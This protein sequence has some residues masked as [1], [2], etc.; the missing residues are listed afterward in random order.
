MVESASLVKLIPT[1]RLGNVYSSSAA[2][3]LSLLGL[4]SALHLLSSELVLAT[5]DFLVCYGVLELE[6]GVG[7]LLVVLVVEA[8]VCNAGLEG[9]VAACVSAVGPSLAV[10]PVA[11]GVRL[12]GGSS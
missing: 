6:L 8:V 12:V 3:L 2:D 4:A 5:D 7:V 1:S 11:S 9:T 10:G